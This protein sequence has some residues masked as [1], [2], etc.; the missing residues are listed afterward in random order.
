MQGTK[1]SASIVSVESKLPSTD[2]A[3]LFQRL[4]PSQINPLD[5]SKSGLISDT[6]IAGSIGRNELR[7]C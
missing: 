7:G 5:S 6:D 2:T 4:N 3:T 1:L